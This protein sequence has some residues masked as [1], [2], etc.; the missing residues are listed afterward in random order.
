M[1]L[2]KIEFSPPALSVKSKKQQ[3]S[4]SHVYESP[5]NACYRINFLIFLVRYFFCKV[6]NSYTQNENTDDKTNDFN[7]HYFFLHF[8]KNTEFVITNTEPALWTNA[9]TTGFKVPMMAGTVDGHEERDIHI[10][11]NFVGY[12]EA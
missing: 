9:P 4:A 8:N 3:R 2:L 12:I 1:C 11:Y 10:Y 5:H 7:C 6:V